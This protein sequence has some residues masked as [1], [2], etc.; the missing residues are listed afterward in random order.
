MTQAAASCGV[1]CRP[2]SGLALL[3]HRPAAAAPFWPLAWELPYAAGEAKKK[4]KKKK[5]HK[6]SVTGL[7]KIQ[8]FWY[9]KIF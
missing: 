7:K 4:K 2:G 1:A 3:W 9:E 8:T 5:M 6:G